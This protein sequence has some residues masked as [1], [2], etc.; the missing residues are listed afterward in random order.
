MT[1]EKFESEVEVFN[2][3]YKIDV[4]DRTEKKESG[5]Q[6]LTYL[7]WAHAWAEAKKVYDIDYEI[8][9]WDGKPY[10]YDPL[11]GYL[12]MTKMTIESQTY[13]MW[14]PVMDYH[15]QAMKAEAYQLEF[16]SGK[17]TINPATMMDINKTIMRCLVKNL[18]MFGLGLYIYAGE[19][20]PE[21]EDGQFVKPPMTAEN[22]GEIRITFGKYSG[23]KLSE[24]FEKD[25]GYITWLSNDSKND[26]IKNA[27]NSLL[28][29]EIKG[30]EKE[31]EPKESGFNDGMFI[32]RLG[33]VAEL[34]EKDPAILEAF[35]Y[36][37][38]SK[39]LD[40]EVKTLNDKTAPIYN[41]YLRLLETKA[42]AKESKKQKEAKAEQENLFEGGTTNPVEWG[43]K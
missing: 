43:K 31:V 19:D 5:S 12:V 37:E 27:A 24:I 38:V 17:V 11:L 9:E 36:Q 3:L 1:N 14:L 2:K 41:K 22:A 42:Q 39:E 29:A 28:D 21:N 33:K 13:E 16:K 34:T 32:E 15:N 18:A 8:K 20:I 40:E 6:S 7:S 26:D 4:S 23:E 35:I 30:D 25:V 10:L